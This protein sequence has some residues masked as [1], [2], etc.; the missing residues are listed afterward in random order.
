MRGGRAAAGFA[1]VRLRSHDRPADRLGG[2]QH[3]G[4]H[5]FGKPCPRLLRKRVEPHLRALS[6]ERDDDGRHAAIRLSRG[7][8]C[9]V[10]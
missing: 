1:L 5:R 7:G 6:A 3:I 10:Q 9:P 4:E 2:G 8:Q